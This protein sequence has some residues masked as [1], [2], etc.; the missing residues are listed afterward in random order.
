MPKKSFNAPIWILC[1]SAIFTFAVNYFVYLTID[2]INTTT[3]LKY[4]SYRFFYVWIWSALMLLDAAIYFIIRKKINNKAFAWLHISCILLTFYVL[5]AIAPIL[6]F[7]ASNYLSNP[8][9]L[10]IAMS[11]RRIQP[12]MM[13]FILIIGHAFFIAT[14]AKSFNKKRLSADNEQSTGILTGIVDE[15]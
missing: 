15:H 2:Q 11:L 7:I 4:P 5:P 10:G 13:W 6:A 9:M 8:G 1:V 14:I 3:T 12:L